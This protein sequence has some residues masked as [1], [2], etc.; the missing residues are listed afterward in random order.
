MMTSRP[1]TTTAPPVATSM[2]SHQGQEMPDDRSAAQ[3]AEMPRVVAPA[4]SYGVSPGGWSR[5]REWVGEGSLM[6][7]TAAVMLPLPG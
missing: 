3:L 5:A 1:H 2:M 6:Q 4:A 7:M